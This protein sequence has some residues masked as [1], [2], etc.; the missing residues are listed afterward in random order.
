M[1]INQHYNISNKEA[2]HKKYL[3]LLQELLLLCRENDIKI[4]LFRR[5]AKDALE[6]GIVNDWPEVCIFAEDAPRLIA[7]VDSDNRHIESRADNEM[8]KFSY[9]RYQDITTTDF[10]IE[11]TV[12]VRNHCMYV[13]IALIEKASTDSQFDMAMIEQEAEIKRYRKTKRNGPKKGV[14]A[15][16]KS[17][18]KKSDD[19]NTDLNEMFKK[20][21]LGPTTTDGWLIVSDQKFAAQVFDA[22]DEI[23][24]EGIQC[25]TPKQNEQ[26][27]NSFY[28]PKWKTQIGRNLYIA[29]A[30][31]FRT[32]SI[33][34]EDYKEA[35]N[36]EIEEAKPVVFALR[37]LKDVIKGDNKKIDRYGYLLDR[38][39]DRISLWQ[40]YKGRETEL[41]NLKEK[42]SHEELMR[43]LKPLFE[44]LERNAERGLGLNFNNRIFAIAMEAL[45]DNGQ[46]ELAEKYEMLVPKEYEQDLVIKDW[47]GNIQ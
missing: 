18:L 2:C 41:Q 26:I 6:E 42:D 31:R 35:I 22:G 16:L 1:D 40:H 23:N 46:S 27:M 7:L 12:N 5:T 15:K 25:L 17:I 36:N 44:A 24:V 13:K 20:R 4:Y 8:F 10:N 21:C 39:H 38:T 47:K 28:G 9:M 45:R 34:W 19:G 3:E 11:E 29:E 30:G 14:K 37:K 43:E 32:P 33:P